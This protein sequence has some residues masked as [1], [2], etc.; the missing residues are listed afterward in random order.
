MPPMLLLYSTG[1]F[2]MSSWPSCPALDRLFLVTKLSSWM[3]LSIVTALLSIHFSAS[4]ISS[5]FFD[6][7]S[8][9]FKTAFNSIGIPWRFIWTVP[10]APKPSRRRSLK[11]VVVISVKWWPLPFRPTNSFNTTAWVAPTLEVSSELSFLVWQYYISLCM[12]KCSM[13]YVLT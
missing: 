9:F 12:H 13:Y 6:T 1:G 7:V 5:I 4:M 8:P 3:V 2:R 10:H 11:R